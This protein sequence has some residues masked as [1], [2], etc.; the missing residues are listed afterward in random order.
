MFGGWTKSAHLLQFKGQVHLLLTDG[1]PE[2]NSLQGNPFIRMF[3]SHDG[4]LRDVPQSTRQKIN[5]ATYPEQRLLH[6]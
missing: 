4:Q 3:H 6:V 1:R 2:L 5:V